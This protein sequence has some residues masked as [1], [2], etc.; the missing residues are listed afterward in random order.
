MKFSG[1]PVHENASGPFLRAGK[2]PGD[3]RRRGAGRG[4]VSA[5]LFVWEKCF[6]RTRFRTRRKQ[7]GG[8][9]ENNERMR[10]FVLG[11]P[12]L[13]EAGEGGTVGIGG[14]LYDPIHFPN[15]QQV[16]RKQRNNVIRITLPFVSS[17]A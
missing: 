12:S 1:G 13:M 14:H 16:M 10:L 9:I 8:N 5:A 15:T 3:G 7:K 17:M 6:R 2:V 11:L 4:M